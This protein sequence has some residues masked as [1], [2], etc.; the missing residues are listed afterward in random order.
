MSATESRPYVGNWKESQLPITDTASDAVIRV[1]GAYT[2]VAC[3]A[4]GVR[5][6]LNRYLTEVS[7]DASTET[8]GMSASFT[9][10][11]PFQLVPDPQTQLVRIVS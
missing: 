6:D 7:V 9:L 8:L 3:T 2:V 10:A 5:I 11:I 4:C 1:N